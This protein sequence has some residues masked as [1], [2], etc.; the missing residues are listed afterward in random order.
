M[1]SC[2]SF[3]LLQDKVTSAAG[4]AVDG[5]VGSIPGAPTSGTAA[6]IG[7]KISSAVSAVKAEAESALETAKGAV[8]EFEQTLQE[9]AE[10]TQAKIDDLVAQMQGATQEV[11]AELEQQIENLKGK[12][13]DAIPAWMNKTPE[14]LLLDAKN[15]ICDPKINGLVAPKEGSAKKMV[16]AV[17]PAVDPGPTEVEVFAAPPKPPINQNP[18]KL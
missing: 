13:Q 4:R 8:A 6:S 2:E 12:V 3:D 9:F 11:I 17:A 1:S 7:A 16:P 10:E 14:E 15:G 5:I 18:I